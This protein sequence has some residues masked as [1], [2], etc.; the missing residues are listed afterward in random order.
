MEVDDDH[1]GKVFEDLGRLCALANNGEDAYLVFAGRFR[2]Q[3]LNPLT[4]PGSSVV[5]W[6]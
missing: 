4:K 5:V 3:L 2:D 1:I 6:Q